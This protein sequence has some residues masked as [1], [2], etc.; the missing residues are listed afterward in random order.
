MITVIHFFVVVVQLQLSAFSPSD[1]LLFS[2]QPQLYTDFS[3]GH[4]SF[5]QNVYAVHIC[6]VDIETPH[7]NE[8]KK[9]TRIYSSRLMKT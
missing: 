5:I 9:S 1:S 3:S 7:G 6:D 2:N 4:S 8:R